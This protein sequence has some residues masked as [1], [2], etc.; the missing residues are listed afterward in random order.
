MSLEEFLEDQDDDVLIRMQHENG[1]VVTFLTAASEVF[2]NK[3]QLEPL[4]FGISDTDIYVVFNSELLESM[5]EES[6]EKN[7]KTYGARAASFLP[8]TMILD[9]GLKAVDKYLETNKSDD[10][11]TIIFEVGERKS[12]TDKEK[13]TE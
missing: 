12:K 10:L 13:E 9:K 6:V 1:T 3:E 7:G 4:V 8:I 2:T 5:I 11:E